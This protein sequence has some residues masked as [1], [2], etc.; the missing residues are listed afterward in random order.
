M[1]WICSIIIAFL[2]VVRAANNTPSEKHAINDVAGYGSSNHSIGESMWGPGGFGKAS[3]RATRAFRS[4][5]AQ[6]L[7]GVDRERAFSLALKS[8]GAVIA[9]SAV[10]SGGLIPACTWVSNDIDVWSSGARGSAGHFSRVSAFVDSIMGTPTGLAGFA[11]RRPCPTSPSRA[12]EVHDSYFGASESSMRS[13]QGDGIVKPGR[14]DGSEEKLRS[15]VTKTAVFTPGAPPLSIQLII[16]A[17]PHAAVS[18]QASRGRGGGGGQER[19]NAPPVPRAPQ[20]AVDGFDLTRCMAA[21]DGADVYTLAAD[22]DASGELKQP[23]RTSLNRNRLGG[24]GFAKLLRTQ[25]RVHKYA[26]RGII[27]D[28]ADAAWLMSQLSMRV[29]EDPG[30]VARACSRGNTEACALLAA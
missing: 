20:A 25:G 2:A 8:D 9:G 10:L 19:A 22:M 13:I 3:A 27:C 29:A 14:D 1:A 4:F 5:L 28:A 26:A 15:V 24:E 7:G 18:E 21:Y 6:K 16:T 12:A 30:V 17:W 11:G 23:A